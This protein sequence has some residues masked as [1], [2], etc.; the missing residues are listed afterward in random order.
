MQGPVTPISGGQELQMT[1]SLSHDDT[2]NAIMISLEGTNTDTNSYFTDLF[3]DTSLTL[4]TS[5]S[6]STYNLQ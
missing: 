1:Y 5:T 4:S 2:D 3:N 6:P